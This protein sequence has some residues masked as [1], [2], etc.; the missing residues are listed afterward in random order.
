MPDVATV[1][2][3]PARSL[4]QRFDALERANRVRVHR[5]ALKK[6]L[7]AG[8]RAIAK[9]LLDPPD[10]L[11]TAKVYDVLLAAPKY[12]RVKVNKVLAQCRIS[13]SKTVGGMSER[14]RFELVALLRSATR[15]TDRAEYHREYGRARPA[16]ATGGDAG[17]G[18]RQRRLE[19]VHA[20]ALTGVRPDGDGVRTACHRVVAS[21]RATL[22][23]RAVTCAACRSIRGLP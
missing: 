10:Y 12:G 8:R 16:R 22:L 9:V 1:T 17:R 20:L 18:D 19:T 6:D 3:A 13:P 23:P 4:Q 2:A 7:K 14:Q 5:A 11:L 15:S 21:D